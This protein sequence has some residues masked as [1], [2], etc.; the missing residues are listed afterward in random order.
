MHSVHATARVI[1]HGRGSTPARLRS[2][3]IQPPVVVSKPMDLA[4]I[5]PPLTANE[6]PVQ[7]GRIVPGGRHV[8]ERRGVESDAL[9]IS[10][11]AL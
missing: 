9:M 4:D 11:A 2:P 6:N 10:Q 7:L 3:V 1:N 8:A 5:E